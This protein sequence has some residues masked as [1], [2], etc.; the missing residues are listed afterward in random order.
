VSRRILVTDGEQ[1][2][3]LAAVRSLGSAGHA[4]Y[5]CAAAPGSLAGASR[6][7]LGEAAVPDPLQG[8][9]EYVAAIAALL[10]R[11][12]VDLLLPITEA[13]M[14]AVLGSAAAFEGVCLPLPSLQAFR[15]IS[16]KARVLEAARSLGIAVPAQFTLHHR[17]ELPAE[18]SHPLNFPL[19]L[20]PARSVVGSSSGRIKLGVRYATNAEALAAELGRMPDAA[21]PI[22]LQQ[23]IVGRGVGV[24][25]LL[26]DGELRAVFAHR[27]LREK[28]PSGGVS[29]YRESI[30]ADPRLVELSQQLLRNFDWQGVA[31]VEYKVDAET[32]VPY[33]ME[34]NGR[35]W[36]SLQLAV[37]AGVDFPNLL[38]Q[39]ALG[40]APSQPP[41]YRAGIRSRW[42][43]GDV[44]H[45]ILRLRRPNNG[46]AAAAE[47]KGR[48]AAI[49]EFL[50]LW[51]PGDRN[52]VFRWNDPAPALRETIHWLQGK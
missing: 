9:R 1:R 22:L 32:G 27:R 6:Y 20:K 14:L 49:V 18:R 11:W 44:D 37:D 26:W 25:V 33:L 16:D 13:S 36:G 23:R 21:Y 28:P 8:E 46:A 42:W 17:A 40:E 3:S 50:K 48:L 52:E 51:R 38:V 34:V 43:W 47:S 12:N 45:L 29:V 24:F 39:C 35:F 7:A 19:V 10:D 31:M 30:P 2:A 15:S 5:V 4:V 41:T